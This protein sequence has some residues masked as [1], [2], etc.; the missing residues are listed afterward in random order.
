MH[1]DTISLTCGKAAF[2][3]EWEA[4]CNGYGLLVMLQRKP[5]LHFVRD[6]ADR[7]TVASGR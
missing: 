7:V 6:L 1:G 4:W 5:K 2:R 3:F